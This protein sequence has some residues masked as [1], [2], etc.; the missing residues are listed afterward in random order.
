MEWEEFAEKVKVHVLLKWVLF[1]IHKMENGAMKKVTFAI[2]VAICF[3]VAIF[4]SVV[5]VALLQNIPVTSYEFIIFGSITATLAVMGFIHLF[6]LFKLRHQ[7][8]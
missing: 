7:I 8:L 2:I 1:R 6:T 4:A 5:F 3:I